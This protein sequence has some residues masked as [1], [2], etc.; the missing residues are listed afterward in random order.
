[1]ARSHHREVGVFGLGEPVERLSDRG[2]PDAFQL[3]LDIGSLALAFEQQPRAAIVVRRSLRAVGRRRALGSGGGQALAGVDVDQ[4]EA[5]IVAQEQ[6]PE[7]YRV[8]SALAAVDTHDH[9]AKQL[10][11][12]THRQRPLILPDPRG[13]QRAGRE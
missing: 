11:S 4:R 5:T 6:P 13:G 3:G 7:R 10:A 1:M 9:G 12:V 8:A 2:R